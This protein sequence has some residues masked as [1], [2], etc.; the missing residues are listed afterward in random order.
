MKVLDLDAL[1]QVKA[2]I[3]IGGETLTASPPDLGSLI[4]IVKL[5][6][7]FGSNPE[8]VLPAIMGLIAKSIPGIEKHTI[9][10][11]HIVHIV[12]FLVSIATPSQVEELD[13]KGITVSTDGLKKNLD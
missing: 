6:N 13:K 9:S 3:K 5:S 8:K 7:E 4:E 10:L 11:D 12:N 2:E 1:V